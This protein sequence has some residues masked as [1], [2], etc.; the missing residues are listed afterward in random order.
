VFHQARKATVK[1]QLTSKGRKL[2]KAG[3]SVKITTNATFTPTGGTPT[4][5]TSTTAL[6]P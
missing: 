5:T 4:S 1:L 6:K 3:K 2:L